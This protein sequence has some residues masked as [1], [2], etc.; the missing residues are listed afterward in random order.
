MPSR[1]RMMRTPFTLLPIFAAT[2][3]S[4]ILPSNANCIF[5]QRGP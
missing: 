3:M 2:A 1:H 5:V 4:G